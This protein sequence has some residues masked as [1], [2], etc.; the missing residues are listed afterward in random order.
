[1]FVN[2]VEDRFDTMKVV[3]IG[4]KTLDIDNAEAYFPWFSLARHPKVELIGFEP[5]DGERRK[6]LE[7]YAGIGATFLPDVVG[8][9]SVRRFYQSEYSDVCGCY[10][11]PKS[12]VEHLGYPDSTTRYKSVEKIQTRR[13]D[14]IPEAQGTDFLKVDTKGAELDILQH[15]ENI[16][17]DALVVQLEMNLT[18]NQDGGCMYFEVGKF[19]H[20][21]GFLVHKAK[22]IACLKF[23]PWLEPKLFSHHHAAD[24]VF[25]RDFRR[26]AEMTPEKLVKCA[27][28]LQDIYLSFDF[29]SLCLRTRDKMT[30]DDLFALHAKQDWPPYK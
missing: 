24:F 6:L 28:I 11:V 18:P 30:G 10:P 20:D 16:L 27:V 5:Q 17:A 26:F 23:R 13:L 2:R 8:D 4:A 1:M 19:M 25:V 7:K 29:A 9:G 12:L 14:D 22:P 21:H 3:D 15:A